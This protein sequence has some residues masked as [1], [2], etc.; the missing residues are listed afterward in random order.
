MQKTTRKKI[1]AVTVVS[2]VIIALFSLIRG[3]GTRSGDT[4]EFEPAIIGTVEKT[5]SVTGI[6][7]VIDSV[8]VAAK[9]T[10]VVKKV[11][12]DFNQNVKKGTLLAA[13][14]STDME[15]RLAKI[16]AQIE[17]GKIE[18]I[19]AREDLESKR[20]LFKENLISEKGLE[21]AEFNYKSLEYK[22]K[23]IQVDYNIAKKMKADARIVAPISGII[24]AR[25]V[26]ENTPVP[27]NTPLFIIAPSLKNMRLIISIDESDIGMIKKGQAVTFTVSAFQDKTFSGIINQVRINPVVKGGLVTYESVV[28]CDNSKLLLKPGMTATATIQI[29]K[30]ENVLRVPNQALLISPVE[31]EVEEDK[32]IVWRKAEKLTGNIPAE[33]VPVEI[34]LRGDNFTEI[35]KNIKKGDLILIKFIRGGKGSGR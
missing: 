5:I 17:S 26:E 27:L 20:S 2:A 34:G 25:T 6:L 3:C 15:Q 12:A 33:K 22:N 30:K 11:Y 4:L 7:E 18:M 29:S 32:N 19:I 24:I 14:D 13:M 35:K 1:I 23:Q 10:G 21:R 9:S 28:I 16:A 8:R 31:D